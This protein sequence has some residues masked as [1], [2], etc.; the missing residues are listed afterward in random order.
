[1]TV[2]IHNESEPGWTQRLADIL[3]RAK[4]GDILVVSS[5]AVLDLAQNALRR[6][7]DRKYLRIMMR[8]TYARLEEQAE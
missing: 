7:E 3:D 6:R 8:E 5:Y 1:M 2:H 4:D